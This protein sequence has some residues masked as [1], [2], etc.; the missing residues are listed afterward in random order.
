MSLL[1]DR[2][3][4]VLRLLP[5]SYRAEREE[6]MVDAFLEGSAGAV[7]EDNARPTLPEVA[8][9]AALAI[10]VR[11]A[12]GGPMTGYVLWGEA[13]RLAALLGLGY[14]AFRGWLTLAA[15]VLN[16]LPLDPPPAG[17]AAEGVLATAARVS[18]LLGFAVI[19]AFAAL[20][21]GR[22]RVAKVLASISLLPPL[23]VMAADSSVHAQWDAL[24]WMP[25]LLMT[26][27][28]Y[29]A[30]MLGFHR[31]VRA[32]HRPA[33]LI[34]VPVLA[35]A[36]YYPLTGIGE[37][38]PAL[39][40][41]LAEPA[42]LAIIVAGVVCLIWRRAPVAWPPALAILAVPVVSML[43]PYSRFELSDPL[44]RAMALVA[45]GQAAVLVVVAVALVL[46]VRRTIPTGPGVGG[47]ARA[48]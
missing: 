48:T 26:A 22:V 18:D 2:Y 21:T 20:V 13:V 12:G 15:E 39:A 16:P 41:A 17:T 40:L 44:T 10:R 38:V 1:E 46:R 34:A 43:A 6:E 24:S 35:A 27:V 33:W 31:D 3:R 11:L 30:L 4:H 25:V 37:P 7:D 36:A 32:V 9:V 5:A 23:A 47:T 8:S 45:A 28:P 42:G 29:L 14:F 19:V